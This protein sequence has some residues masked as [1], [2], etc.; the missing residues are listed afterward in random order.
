MKNNV[1]DPKDLK[2]KGGF[3]EFPS[4]G[5]REPSFWSMAVSWLWTKPENRDGDEDTGTKNQSSKSGGKAR[6]P[7]VTVDRADSDGDPSALPPKKAARTRKLHRRTNSQGEPIVLMSSPVRPAQ[8][9]SLAAL[10]A[11]S[12]SVPSTNNL[13]FIQPKPLKSQQSPGL[14]SWMRASGQ[15]GP[16]GKQYWMPDKNCKTCYECQSEFGLFLRRHHCRLCGHVF[17]W[18]CSDHSVDG[19]VLNCSPG[20]LRLCNYCYD[21]ILREHRRVSNDSSIPPTTSSGSRKHVRTLSGATKPRSMLSSL[22]KTE[23]TDTLDSSESPAP[24]SHRHRNS[25][26]TKTSFEAFL[27]PGIP[28]GDDSDASS[29]TSSSSTDSPLVVPAA[30]KERSDSLGMAFDDDSVEDP[31][32]VEWCS[33]A[34]N[35][36]NP[37]PKPS[38]LHHSSSPQTRASPSPVM[39]GEMH[40]TTDSLTGEMQR[41]RERQ[42]STETDSDGALTSPIEAQSSRPSS[43]VFGHVEDSDDIIATSPRPTELSNV[44]ELE[45]SPRHTA[46][47][48]KGRGESIS[49]LNPAF[50]PPSPAD[51]MPPGSVAMETTSSV[52]LRS[53]S[54][55]AQPHVVSVSLTQGEPVS[56][57]GRPPSGATSYVSAGSHVASSVPSDPTI[58]GNK[59]VNAKSLSVRNDAHLAAV[60]RTLLQQE[61]LGSEWMDVL[62]PF[63]RDAVERVMV[64]VEERG[65]NMDIRNYVKVKRIAGGDM[66]ECAY[67]DGVVCRKNVCHRKMRRSIP[68]ARLLLFSV[69]L[70]YQ[71]RQNVLTTLAPLLEQETEYIRILVSKI[72]AL[73]PDVVICQQSV[74]RLAQELLLR[75]NIA[76]VLNVKVGVMERIARSSAAVILGQTD[77]IPS[78]AVGV[79]GMFDVKTFVCPTPQGEEER[80]LSIDG[81]E[82]KAV[83]PAAQ[84]TVDRRITMLYIAGCPRH[85]NGTI[86]LRGSGDE[87]LR[88]VKRVMRFALFAAYH[89]RCE[90]SL[91]LNKWA[92]PLPPPSPG[93]EDNLDNFDTDFS[94]DTPPPEKLLSISPGVRFV[95]SGRGAPKSEGT[96]SKSDTSGGHLPRDDHEGVSSE[97]DGDGAQETQ[98]YLPGFKP[99]LYNQQSLLVLF[100]CICPARSRTP[101][102]ME[103]KMISYYT[104]TDVT[105][106]QYLMDSCYNASLRCQN[107]KCKKNVLHHLRTYTHNTG[108]LKIVVEKLPFALPKIG[109]KQCILTWQFCKECGTV[110]T[111]ATPLNPSSWNISFGKFLEILFYQ[112]IGRCCT[113]VCHHS[114]A[115]THVHMFGYRDMVA[116]F[117]LVPVVLNGIQVP[118]SSLTYNL[119]TKRIL[120]QQELHHVT[121]A[122][123]LAQEMMCLWAERLESEARP[124]SADNPTLCHTVKHPC[125]LLPRAFADLLSRIQTLCHELLNTSD[126]L[127]PACPPV[128]TPFPPLALLRVA[129]LKKELVDL[130]L[131]WKIRLEE[132]QQQVRTIEREKQANSPA[133]TSRLKAVPTTPNASVD[134]AASDRTSPVPA[135]ADGGCE[136]GVAAAGAGA[137]AGGTVNAG[138]FGSA[139]AAI[140]A[141][142]NKEA[143]AAAVVPPLAMQTTSLREGDTHRES[144][145]NA[146]E[147]AVHAE[148]KTGEPGEEIARNG[149]NHISWPLAESMVAP[150]SPHR[151]AS[152]T[153]PLVVEPGSVKK[154]EHGL[155]LLRSVMQSALPPGDPR[156][157]TYVRTYLDD[158]AAHFFVPQALDTHSLIVYED[159][160]SSIIAHTLL[161]REYDQQLNGTQTDSALHLSVHVDDVHSTSPTYTASGSLRPLPEAFPLTSAGAS[162]ANQGT[163][164]H[165]DIA[166]SSSTPAVADAP[167]SPKGAPSPPRAPRAV[168]DTASKQASKPNGAK[169]ETK[170]GGKAGVGVGVEDATAAPFSR[171]GDKSMG[172]SRASSDSAGERE[173]GSEDGIATPEGLEGRLNMELYLKSAEKSHIKHRFSDEGPP[174]SW[175]LTSEKMATACQQAGIAGVG[176]KFSCTVYY[177][178]QFAALR[179][180]YFGG[181]DAYI[182][183]LSRCYKWGARGGKSGASFCKT[184]DERFVV[185]EVH[186]VEMLS[187]LQTAPAY[188]DY[189]AKAFFNKLPT[190]LVKILGIYQV[191]VIQPASAGGRHIK[192]DIVVMENLFY[193]RN[194][195]RIFDLKGSVRSRYVRASDGNL[196]GVVLMDENLLEISQLN[197]LFL[198]EFAKAV[199]S[200]SIWNDTLFLSKLNV[201]DYSLLVGVDPDAEE[202]V[203]GIIDYMR[204]YTW[205]KQLETL[206]KQ[207]G[208]MGGGKG[209]PTVISPK[210]YKQRFRDAMEGYFITAPHKFTGTCKPIAVRR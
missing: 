139:T 84:P 51:S 64:R 112:S 8:K 27:T 92:T 15:E 31:E 26:K 176:A 171:G 2:D 189:V 70:E 206:I 155:G 196:D 46:S 134:P 53:S 25:A 88:S 123:R 166:A 137:S 61:D 117:E 97:A 52:S 146:G 113:R 102:Q 36:P 202:L 107:T 37:T 149:N 21:L 103:M 76:V 99:S 172:P 82:V 144:D 18:K 197:P 33:T 106:G 168:D 174:M 17:C 122:C 68:N 165:A 86:T 62:L 56:C 24:S 114:V 125:Q 67:V 1:P 192:Q 65:D 179:K 23:S 63:A 98:W 135:V 22:R 89:L 105:L 75:D 50:Y 109:S 111:P 153:W 119:R 138:T 163:H 157:E 110:V 169:G 100:S 198:Q 150:L 20:P 141:R 120:L 127:D 124:H 159:E 34:F 3:V 115:S 96:G 183:S 116:R 152:S 129:A 58:T 60:V 81:G 45:R 47:R 48:K 147:P 145:T 66:K 39:R 4:S 54:S 209:D 41:D 170:A 29:V 162:A 59:S 148:R 77:N 164:S 30:R 160:P 210:Q 161:S 193:N 132:Y 72:A 151:G 118:P 40:G 6:P 79:C 180:Q 83:T 158:A 57:S 42:R 7:L 156:R 142:S 186:H 190:C 203:V 85:R 101:H 108:S 199:L 38:V 93:K 74:N 43:P 49:M 94:A 11:V 16:L 204:Q 78:S 90:R 91:L 9:D 185:K 207:T 201:V 71:R 55:S 187:F 208:I 121:V 182:E 19:Q 10:P 140:S 133:H 87:E 104:E 35:W 73:Q 12:L 188:F 13:T 154:E 205:D 194:I 5:D 191:S 128:E 131:L 143:T 177:P 184:L 167:R 181:D 178:K 14:L 32:A 136:S 28:D 195:S 175:G 95:L 69:P 200:M 173:G 130:V 126:P 80:R 44:A